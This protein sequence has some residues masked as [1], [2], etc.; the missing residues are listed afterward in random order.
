MR[1]PL[2]DTMPEAI[3]CTFQDLADTLP[4]ICVREMRFKGQFERWLRGSFVE[5]RIQLAQTLKGCVEQEGLPLPKQLV[6]TLKLAEKLD[7]PTSNDYSSAEKLA[8]MDQLLGRNDPAADDRAIRAIEMAQRLGA[9]GKSTIVV[10]LWRS[11]HLVVILPKKTKGKSP[12]IALARRALAMCPPRGDFA[13]GL[14]SEARKVCVL[15]LASNLA[16]AHQFNEC[17]K[18]CTRELA[19]H[20]AVSADSLATSQVLFVYAGEKEKKEK[21]EY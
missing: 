5:L 7:Q 16:V 6:E 9:T 4:D 3:N 11:F 8:A 19:D 15:K 20:M 2:I 14:A 12:H 1:K 17:F 21:K 18:L 13:I 10:L